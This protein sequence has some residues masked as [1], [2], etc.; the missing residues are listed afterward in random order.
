M[1]LQILMDL[2]LSVQII[3]QREQ[4]AHGIILKVKIHG[5]PILMVWENTQYGEKV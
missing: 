3:M 4:K 1:N 5:I 2:Y